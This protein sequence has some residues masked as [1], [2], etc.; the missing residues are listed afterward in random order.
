MIVEISVEMDNVISEEIPIQNDH[1][2]LPRPRKKRSRERGPS[3][4]GPKSKEEYAKV[5]NANKR[6]KR[7]RIKT[8]K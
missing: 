7:L 2:D 1:L 8:E 5:R 3:E 4:F 6:I